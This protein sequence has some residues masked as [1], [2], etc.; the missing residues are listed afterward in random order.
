MLI[1]GGARGEGIGGKARYV[2]GI[3]GYK[4]PARK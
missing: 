3:K 4:C 2:K 1:T